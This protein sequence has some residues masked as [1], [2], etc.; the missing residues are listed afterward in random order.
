MAYSGAVQVIA[1]LMADVADPTQVLAGIT[2][3]ESGIDLDD[4]SAD[5]AT[6]IV[7]V[8]L[9]IYAFGVYVHES[10]AAAATGSL[11][12]ERATNIVGTD[13]T[14]AELDYDSILNQSGDGDRPFQTT[15]TGSEDIDAGDVLYAQSSLFPVLITAPQVLTVRHVSTGV[16]GEVAPFIVARWQ[17]M[18][19]RPAAV[20]GR[21]D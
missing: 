14:V 18:D 11:F 4:T 2:V 16:A 1:F 13:T 9:M 8:P 20:W 17:G 7:P 19:L 3:A 6:M 10:F 15:S 5:V 21:T 12:L